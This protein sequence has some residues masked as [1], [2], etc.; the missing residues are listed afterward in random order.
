MKFTLLFTLLFSSGIAA[1]AQ[2]S[3]SGKV[4]DEQGKPIPFASIYIKNTTK[5]TSANADGEY[6]LRLAPGGYDVQYKAVGYKQESRNVNLAANRVINV[7]LQA[8]TYQLQEV[9]IGNGE[10]P[11]YAIIRKAIERRKEHLNEV[12]AYTC[13]AYI[14]GMQKLLA[15]PKKFMGFDVQKAAR[16]NGLD[17][18]RHGIVYLSESESKYSF[19]RPD[20]VHEEMISSKVSGS[21]RA[22]SYNRASDVKVDFYENM[23]NWGGLSNRP[24]ISPIAENALFYYKYRY[25]G[26][27]TE[28]GQIIDK[29]KLIPKRS[30]DA[31]FQGYIYILEGDWRIYGVDLFITKKQNINFVDTLGISEQFIPVDQKV[32]MPSSIK[33]EFT[34]SLF[35]FKVGGYFISIFKDY[36]LNPTFDKIEFNEVL[37]VENGANKK[38]SLYWERQR[39]IPLTEEEKTDYQKKAVLARKRESKPYLDSLDSVNNKFKPLAWFLGGYR[40]SNRYKHESFY[41]DPLLTSVKFNTVQG[42]ALNYGA[43]FRKMVDSVNRRFL[44]ADARAGYGFSNHIIIGSAGLALPLG[45]FDFSVR[46]GLEITDLN[47][48]EPISP[49][50]NSLYSLFERENYQMLYQKQYVSASLHRRIIGGWQAT[51]GV[52]WADRKWLPNTSSYSFFSPAG[53]NYTSNNPLT[54]DQDIPLFPQ[55]QS[56]KL[57]FRTTYDFSNKYETYPDGRRYLPSPYP[58]VGF[59]Y[60]KGIS[61][62]FGS[63]VDYDLVSFDVSKS[64]IPVGIFGNTS[65]YLGAGKFI[66]SSSLFYPDYKQFAGNQILFCKNGINSFL[67]LDYYTFSTYKQYA[68]GHFEQNF[69]G[70]FLNKI[71]LIRKLKLQEIVDFNYLYTPELKNYMEL[72]LGIQYLNFRLMYGQSFNSGS[73]LKTGVRIGVSF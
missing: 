2:V 67:L 8:E 35:G 7:V 25:I 49:L 39:P 45:S 58:T 56:F 70:F 57:T 28:N 40:H 30:Y 13:E 37:R 69:S 53:H 72:G 4:T 66:N 46:G 6:V 20:N 31:C 48:T 17:S 5:G 73:N 26:F 16:E 14:K 65:F 36:D 42:F 10:D 41:L 18:N 59:N 51:V 12:N 21:N 63:D 22:F 32:W 47:S 38:D 33:F 34:A 1:F 71:P 15:A 68:E 24:V 52:E 55:N 29:I 50:W 43:S 19:Q 62:L 54:P 61:G 3:V 44:E 27:T 60:V 9:V 23:Q 64:D 11:A